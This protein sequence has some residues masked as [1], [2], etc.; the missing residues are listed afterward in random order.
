[1]TSLERA[2]SYV[3]R[4]FN[5]V[6]IP[7]KQKAPTIPDWQ[8]LRIG[9]DN[10]DQYFN[11]EQLNIGILLGT[12]WN[13]TDVDI[14]CRE[15]LWA[16]QEFL[17]ETHWLHGRQSKPSSHAFYYTDEPV[18]TVRFQD[19]IGDKQACLLE[20]RSYKAN[21]GVGIQTVA[22]GSVHPSGEV[23]EFTPG[24]SG[25]PSQVAAG[26]LL[27]A[28]KRI[29]ACALLGRYA[30]GDGRRHELFLAV[31][32]ALAHAKWLLEDA[33]RVVRSIYRILWGERANLA[34][35]EREVEST[36]QRYD[37]G[38]EITGIPHL[39]EIYEEKVLKKVLDWLELE[40]RPAARAKAAKQKIN[41]DHIQPRLLSE[42][43]E[44][45][46]PMPQQLVDGL[47]NTPSLYIIAGASK[48]GKT[49]LAVQIGMSIA[50]GLELFGEYQTAQRGVL[51]VE[52]DDPN[53]ET[54]LK[55]LELKCRA[56]RPGAPIHYVANSDFE[57]GEEFTGWLR[58]K[59]K[60]LKLGVIIL[61][62][63]T[64]LRG[65]RVNH[66]DFVK[67][68]MDELR[69]L[70]DLAREAGV[71]IILIHHYSKSSSHLHHTMRAA[72]SFAVGA[73]TGA[74]LTI[75]RYEDL[76]PGDTAR[77][78]QL[79]GHGLADKMLAL[80]FREDTLDFDFIMSGPACERY[81]DLR[82]LHL[83]FGN[84]AFSAKDVA[85]ELGWS[86]PTVYRICD[87]LVMAGVLAKVGATWMWNPQFD[88]R[89]L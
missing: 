25:D 16:A 77:R 29:A 1:M 56:S 49:V 17:P 51:V 37:D 30:P 84:Q 4:G 40:G 85:G 67:A 87:R 13:V 5:V 74:L 7:Y 39:Q 80:R 68:E 55:E 31:A 65:A 2:R 54:A 89:N 69:Q 79:E 78:V 27:T 62:S 28:G 75:E 23:V 12:P 3:V 76:L 48:S 64:A 8:N 26:E 81:P 10:V 66:A 50:S 44:K 41:Y 61:D 70:A 15:A 58:K 72:G 57:F 42:L 22:P 38:G 52:K 11:G 35:A 32:G 36:F 19:P 53:G 59:I 73:A 86:R 34:A 63:L 71:T 45:Q 18:R 6:P 9:L 60:E 88:R 82:R 33:C 83:T 24:Y 21:G 47:V 20:I 14:D 46:I 43:R